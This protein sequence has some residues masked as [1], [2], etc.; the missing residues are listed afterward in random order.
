MC[1]LARKWSVYAEWKSTE[2]LPLLTHEE[3]RFWKRKSASIPG[4]LN[5]L[6][7]NAS[8][9]PSTNRTRGE[10][11]FI[12]I[13]SL[14][15]NLVHGPVWLG[16][17]GVETK[18]THR[19]SPYSKGTALISYNLVSITLGSQ[20]TGARLLRRLNFLRWELISVGPRC[21]T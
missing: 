1:G 21:G 12:L 5:Y 6:E 15:C 18:F 3:G 10:S 17:G 7:M 14:H 2:D 16:W 4:L 20:I 8:A 19:T 13:L 9:L 11:P